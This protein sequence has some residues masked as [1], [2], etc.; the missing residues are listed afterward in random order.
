M[1]HPSCQSPKLLEALGELTASQVLIR[2]EQ[3]LELPGKV[4]GYRGLSRSSKRP[5]LLLC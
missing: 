5:L 4:S 2:D 3:D 1:P